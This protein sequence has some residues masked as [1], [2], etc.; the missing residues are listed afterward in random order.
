[1]WSVQ[2]DR[3][4][5]LR[6]LFHYFVNVYLFMTRSVDAL[7]T[8][9][10]RVWCTMLYALLY[11]LCVIIVKFSTKLTWYSMV[12]WQ[13]SVIQLGGPGLRP[14]LSSVNPLFPSLSWTPQ[15]VWAEPA[16]LL[17]NILMQF[18][19]SNSLIKSTSMFNV[20][21]TRYRNQRACRV[22]PLSAELILWIAGHV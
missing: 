5:L 14:P 8:S 9:C 21:Y 20:Y 4:T 3:H 10:V 13:R 12:Q 22:Q 17:P 15:G 2:P 19:Q 1:M 6:T 7:Q 18:I 16:H 11:F